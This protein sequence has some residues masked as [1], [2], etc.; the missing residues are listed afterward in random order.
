MHVG[1]NTFTFVIDHC[2]IAMSWLDSSMSPE[3]DTIVR[4]H[5][6]IPDVLSP[7]MGEAGQRDSHAVRLDMVGLLASR[8]PRSDAEALSILRGLYPFAP[9]ADRVGAVGSWRSGLHV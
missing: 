6:V 2:K 3:G 7:L 5:F 8:A 4:S 1:H 9:L